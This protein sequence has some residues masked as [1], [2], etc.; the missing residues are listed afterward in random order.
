MC[1]AYVMKPKFYFIAAVLLPSLLDGVVTLIGQ[2]NSYW[3]DFSKI[4]EA[5]PVTFLMFG[6]WVFL[7]SVVVYTL[8]LALLIYK[9]PK[10]V[11]I[12]VGLFLC[13]SHSSGIQ[14]W[15][16]YIITEKMQYLYDYWWYISVAYSLI[17]GIL[18]A[19][20]LREWLL[21]EF[22]IKKQKT[23]K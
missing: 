21:T 16:P 10:W 19:I 15:A 6:P 9:L 7:L 8:L 18:V 5:S 2:P 14:S 1:Y 11:S 23:K 4:D 17:I 13:M 3:T 20:S 12:G 22:S